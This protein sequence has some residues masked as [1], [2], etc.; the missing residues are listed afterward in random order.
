[1]KKSLFYFF[2]FNVASSLYGQNPNKPIFKNNV[3]IDEVSLSKANS[4]IERKKLV[5]LLPFN[6][7]KIEGDT[8]NT[9]A[10]R[11]KKDKFL[12]ITLD[13][14]AGAL[15]AIDSAKTIGFPV[16]VSIFDS[17]ET[18]NT[19]NVVSIIQENSLQDSDAIIGPFY[20]HNIEIASEILE[21]YTVPVISPLSKDTGNS[22]SN[23]YKSIPS[24]ENLKA[25]MFDYM[26][27]KEGNIIAVV[28]K[29]IESARQYIQ[30]NQKGV[31]F[32]ALNENGSLSVESLKQLFVKD[33]I[34]YVILETTNTGMIKW[35]MHTMM[36]AMASYKVQLVILEPNETLDTDE[37]N[38]E[39]LIKLK[40][41]FPSVT[42]EN[43]SE[44]AQL[45]KN[46]FRKRNRIEP[47]S[48]ATRGFDLTFDTLM[49]LS[50]GIKFVETL[51]S[52]AS[53]QIE[54]RFEYY[55]NDLGGY[56]NKSIYILYYDTDLKIKEAK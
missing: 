13:F 35:T 6:L 40:L 47:S 29:K 7:P 18:K 37:I 54:N 12:N 45:F 49:R 41:L 31:S 32:A 39:S 3:S 53:E 28:D 5:L 27:K 14:Y 52:F 11:L 1:M 19:S 15:M 38:L 4:N 10:T 42:R 44:Q 17:Q 33:K 26:R 30:T 21:S 56:I 55:K 36:N 25:A 24:S 16:D 22:F 9:T 8:I 46:E 2:V 48:Y 43:D 50:L 20:Q 51:D 34:N 23:L